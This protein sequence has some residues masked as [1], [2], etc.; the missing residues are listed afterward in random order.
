M[1]DA[2]AICRYLLQDDEDQYQKVSD[3]IMHNECITKIEVLAEVV[4]VLE[5]VYNADRNDVIQSLKALCEDIDIEDSGVL[6]QA[7]AIYNTPPK[8]DFID[9]ILYGYHVTKGYDIMTFDKK[10][11][12]KINSVDVLS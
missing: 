10:L 3:I 11:I 9:C 5:G 7:L 2:N 1:L 4:Y 8:L 6:L 12:S